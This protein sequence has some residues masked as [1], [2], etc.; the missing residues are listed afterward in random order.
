MQASAAADTVSK[1]S[2]AFGAAEVVCDALKVSRDSADGQAFAALLVAL[3]ALKP[4]DLKTRL[5]AAILE[6]VDLDDTPFALDHS[7]YANTPGYGRY[8][9]TWHL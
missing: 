8:N 6:H 7:I 3:L 2:T 9:A 1:G 5:A 4:L